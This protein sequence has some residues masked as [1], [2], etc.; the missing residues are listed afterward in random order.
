MPCEG[1]EAGSALGEAVVETSC[2]CLYAGCIPWSLLFPLFFS[3]SCTFNLQY[4]PPPLQTLLLPL[5]KFLRSQPGLCSVT[6]SGESCRQVHTPGLHQQPCP[7]LPWASIH[8]PPLGTHH[9]AT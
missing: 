9:F 3:M 2:C 6:S 8:M 4:C 1:M 7:S 5:D